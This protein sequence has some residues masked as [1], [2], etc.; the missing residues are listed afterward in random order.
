MLSQRRRLPRRPISLTPLG[1]GGAPLGGLFA[2]VSMRD[3][4]ETV[5][6]AW[7]CGIRFFDTAPYYGYSR[8]ERRL[9]AI[10]DG[11]D[12]AEYVVSSKA[13]R[14]MLPD[15]TVGADED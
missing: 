8:A 6:A 9:G 11:F 2:P 15:A 1:L 7:E 10:L 3:T 4:L 12:R 14:L 13:G 5:E